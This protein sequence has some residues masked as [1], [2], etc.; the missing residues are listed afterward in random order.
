LSE[1]TSQTYANHKRFD[2]IYHALLF[3]ILAA[4]LVLCLVNSFR[5]FT[6]ASAWQALMAIA[7]LIIF[8]KL[9]TYSLRVQD[10]VIRLEENMRLN[11]LLPEALRPRIKELKPSQLV[12]LRFASDAE[13]PE[14]V[15]ATLSEQLSN[16]DIKKRIQ[17]WRPDTFRV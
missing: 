9:R 6:F 14:L 3:A 17:T 2:P 10:R 16:P 13:I 5:A 4:N 15:A 12:A 11:Q 8:A 7:F 1:Q